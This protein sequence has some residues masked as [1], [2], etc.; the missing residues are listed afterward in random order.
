MNTPTRPFSLRWPFVGGALISA[1]LLLLL[2]WPV[3]RSVVEALA[4]YGDLIAHGILAFAAVLLLSVARIA[5]AYGRRLEAQA[6]QAALAHLQDGLPPIHVRDVHDLLERGLVEQSLKRYHRTALAE[7][8]RPFPQLGNY[9]PVIHIQSASEAQMAEEL[10]PAIIEPP[11]GLEE[12]IRRGLATPERWYVGTDDAG[13]PQQ[14]VLKH[15]GFLAISGV[16]GTGKT[17]LAALL[18]SQCAAHGGTLFVADPHLGDDESLASRIAPFSGAV[19]R[20]AVTAEEVN[21]LISKVDKIYQAR[22]RDPQQI[23]GPVLLIVDEFMDLILRGH[24]TDDSI[25]ALLALSGV[26]RK[27]QVFVALISQNWSQR[28]LGPQ[29]VAIRQ[30]VTHALVC[31]SSQETARFL[32]PPSY[33]QQ[34]ML[35]APG[36]LLFFGGN[37]PTLTSSP[38]LSD[39][40]LRLA[41]RGRPPRPYVPWSLAPAPQLSAACPPTTPILAAPLRPTAPVMP[42]RPAPPTERLPPPTVQEQIVFLLLGHPWQTSAEIADALEVDR[43]V[44]RTELYNLYR[45]QAI[46]RRAAQR[47]VAEKYEYA[48]HS[49]TQSL[50]RTLTPTA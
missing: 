28:L 47:K 15:A 7:A 16:Q 26:G 41:A 27:K 22:T 36:Q 10:P 40:D 19:E 33:A 5:L 20:F 12:A 35:L 3:A 6:D 37:E 48:C 8:Q 49:I 13:T 42:P 30:N 1:G 2:L 21:A 44:V 18:A 9:H 11:P 43:D 38:L 17:N 34:A 24:L 39:S 14:I 31:R 29:G 4:G 32:L 23:D 25:A 45:K 46:I 50:N